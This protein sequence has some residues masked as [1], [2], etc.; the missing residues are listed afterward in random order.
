MK[1][2]LW[3]SEENQL[4]TTNKS[5]KVF[6]LDNPQK[7]IFFVL[8]FLFIVVFIVYLISKDS[9]QIPTTEEKISSAIFYDLPEIVVNLLPMANKQNYL[10][11]NLSLQIKNDEEAMSVEKKIPILK[12]TLIMFL[13]ELYPTDFTGSGSNIRLK[14]ELILRVNKVLAP[15]MVEDVLIKDILID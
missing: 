12:D 5:Q 1:N 15:L 3:S 13:R 6:N 14:T 9:K 8:I 4:K 7:I 2:D 10:K 11:I